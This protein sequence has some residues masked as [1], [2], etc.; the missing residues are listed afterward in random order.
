[1]FHVTLS[2]IATAYRTK[3]QADTSAGA[4]ISGLID[5]FN[6]FS[7]PLA[8]VFLV[9]IM[10]VSVLF[11]VLVVRSH[12]RFPRWVAIANPLFI[13]LLL[14]FLASLLPTAGKAFLIVSIYNFSL[15]L[16]YL[17]CYLAPK[18]QARL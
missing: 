8:Y 16:F 9:S 13:Q 17:V 4:E 18:K 14:A 1:M 2:F 3:L 12:S 7:Q 5:Q 11:F 10:V 6:D 15:L